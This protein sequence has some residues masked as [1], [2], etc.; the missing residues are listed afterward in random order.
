M[1]IAGDSPESQN[2][3]K[4]KKEEEEDKMLYSAPVTRVMSHSQEVDLEPFPSYDSSEHSLKRHD[5]DDSSLKIPRK[6]TNSLKLDQNE[7]YRDHRRHKSSSIISHVEPESQEE[8]ND[9]EL[10]LDVNATLIDQHGAWAIHLV[11][12]ILLRLF[13]SIFPGVSTVW[14]WTLTNICYTLGTFVVFHAIKGTPFDFNGG[15]FDNLTLWEQI[16]KETQYTPTRKFLILLPIALLLISSRYANFD[17]I[18]FSVNL[19]VVVLFGVLP[20]LP[21]AHRLRISI[22][23]LIGPAQ[24]G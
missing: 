21:F 17:L 14:S 18:F 19:S 23:G 4:K 12:I 6:R 15:A 16:D 22:P 9:Q 13:F 11:V 10:S 5:D 8:K 24:I 2:W 20:K 1:F 3:T 7:P